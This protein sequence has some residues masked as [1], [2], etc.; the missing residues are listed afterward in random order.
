MAFYVDDHLLESVRY[1]Q[2][3]PQKFEKAIPVEWI[4]PGS[5]VL[6]SAETDKVSMFKDDSRPLGFILISIGLK[7]AR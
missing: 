2:A 5:D 4:T 1:M 3:G 7:P 6:V